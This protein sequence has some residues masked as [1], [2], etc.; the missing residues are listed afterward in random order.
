MGGTDVL[1]HNYV[2]PILDWKRNCG[3]AMTTAILTIISI[4]PLHLFVVYLQNK[5]ASAGHAIKAD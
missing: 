2:Y 3:E 5:F 4:P 1:G